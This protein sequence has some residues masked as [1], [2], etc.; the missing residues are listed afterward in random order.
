MFGF[1]QNSAEDT[2]AGGILIGFRRDPHIEIVSLTTP[3]P[4]DQRSR[5]GFKRRDSGHQALARQHWRESNGLLDYVGEWHSHPEARPS[6]SWLDRNE[7]KKIL[8][9]RNVPMIFAI[10]GTGPDIWLGVGYDGE[11]KALS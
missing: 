9:S 11:I 5:R 10:I 3:L 7:W 6:P 1:Q 2:E 4:K 8:K